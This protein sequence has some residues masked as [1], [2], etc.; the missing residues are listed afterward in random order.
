MAPKKPAISRVKFMPLI[1]GYFTPS[2]PCIRPFIGGAY[3][4]KM[5]RDPILMISWWWTRWRFL[6]KDL[7]W[8]VLYP[9]YLGE[10][11]QLDSPAH[12]SNWLA[13]MPPLVCAKKFKTS[14]H[15]KGGS[16]KKV[17]SSKCFF[18][19]MDGAKKER[20]PPSWSEATLLGCSF[21][22]I[23]GMCSLFWL[24]F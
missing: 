8:I 24:A 9:K 4:Y 18:P 2:Y 21:K 14:H 5:V 15:R 11:M 20:N 12:I 22:Q 13:R 10:R 3:N 23:Y 16:L 7:F 17:A 6:W 1:G 19:K